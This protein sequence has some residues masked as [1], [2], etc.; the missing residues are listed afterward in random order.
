MLAVVVEYLIGLIVSQDY[1]E[2]ARKSEKDFTRRRKM[3]FTNCIWY[4]L[5]TTKRS[6]S[7]GLEA[8]VKELK[9]S[10]DS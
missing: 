3:S 2:A 9:V 5:T 4:L 7:S 8:F 10:W 1:P 6:L